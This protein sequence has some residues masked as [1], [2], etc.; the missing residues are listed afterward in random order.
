M[1][2]SFSYFEAFNKIKLAFG[3][4]WCFGEEVQRRGSAQ[5]SNFDL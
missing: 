4:F 5:G 2:S 3:E 1:E